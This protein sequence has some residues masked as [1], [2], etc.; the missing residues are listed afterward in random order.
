[1]KFPNEVQQ[2]WGRKLIN[3]ASD[4]EYGRLYDF[5]SI[6]SYREFKSRVPISDYEDFKPYIDRMMMC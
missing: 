2:E 1:M 6:N 3:Q 4:T 5:K